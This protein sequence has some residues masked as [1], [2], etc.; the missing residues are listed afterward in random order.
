MDHGSQLELAATHPDILARITKIMIY[1][2]Q[3][4]KAYKKLKKKQKKEKEE[5]EKK[6]KGIFPTMTNLVKNVVEDDDM[7]IFGDV[8]V[9]FFL[10]K[11]IKILNFSKLIPLG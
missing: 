4:A 5:E 9:F 3:G 6:A 10:L 1:Y 7:E 11:V 2:T 8:G